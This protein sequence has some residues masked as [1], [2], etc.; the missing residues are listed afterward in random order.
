MQKSKSFDFLL[1]HKIWHTREL[2]RSCAVDE[3][4]I[5]NVLKIYNFFAHWMDSWDK[6]YKHARGYSRRQNSSEIPI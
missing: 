3:M 4:L 2:S 6:R 1:K 5:F